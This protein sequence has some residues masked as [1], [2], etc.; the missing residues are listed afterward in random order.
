MK[1]ISRMQT[2]ADPVVAARKPAVRAGLNRVLASWK[3]KVLLS[4]H[5]KDPGTS[6]R[7][8]PRARVAA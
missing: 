2:Q 5:E 1:E 8:S 3:G 6:G 4:W 7:T